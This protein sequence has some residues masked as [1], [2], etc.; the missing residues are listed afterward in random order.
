[1][2][3]L[4]GYGAVPPQLS[5]QVYQSAMTSNTINVGGSGGSISAMNIPSNLIWNNDSSITTSTGT[6][7]PSLQVNG[8]AKFEHDVEMLGDLKVKGR[9]ISESL[10]KIEERLRIMHPN[11]E[12]E[13]RWEELRKIGDRY[14]ELEAELLQCEEVMEILGK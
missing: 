12:L 4:N 2:S 8:R 9:S 5:G 1:M 6:H 13:S 10:A 14:R 11:R 7:T 3:L